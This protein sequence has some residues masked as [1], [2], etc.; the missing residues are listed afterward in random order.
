MLLDPVN[1]ITSVNFYKKVAA[2]GP[3]RTAL[4]L[5]YLSAVFAVAATLAVKVRVGPEIDKTFVWLAQSMPTLTLAGG[6]I[7]SSSPEPVTLRHP[8]VSEIAVTIDT[9]RT[10]PV[11]PETLESAK[12][13]AVLTSSTLYLRGS[14]PGRMETYDLSKANAPKP[15]VIDA[16]FYQTAGKTL[17]RVLYPLTLIISFFLVVFW[18]TAA[19]VIYSLMALMINA[20]AQ[21]N[22]PYGSLFNIAAYAQTLVVVLQAIL[23]FMPAGVPGF[24]V[25]SAAVTG[26]YIWL[27][28]KRINQPAQP[29]PAA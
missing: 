26:V 17:T 1:A 20:V 25:I 10:E 16:S 28:L 4:Y 3:G 2:Q 27:A 15:V 9:S 22:Q 29:A 24:S 19:S 6:R 7:T 5:V 23:L 11:T 21:G 12:V 14:Q 8:T 18:K 13:A